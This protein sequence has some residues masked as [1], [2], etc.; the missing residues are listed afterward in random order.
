ML[1]PVRGQPAELTAVLM[2]NHIKMMDAFIT[3]T[4]MACSS[5]VSRRR[6]CVGSKR[7]PKLHQA[8]ACC[9]RLD[10]PHGSSNNPVLSQEFYRAVSN[11][12]TAIVEL[13]QF[14]PQ[15]RLAGNCHPDPEIDP[16]LPICIGMN[17]HQVCCQWTAITTHGEGAALA[18]SYLHTTL[19]PVPQESRRQKTGNPR[20]KTT[21]HWLR[22][23]TVCSCNLSLLLGIF[24][25]FYHMCSFQEK[26][27]K[28][29]RIMQ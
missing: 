12:G 8:T 15:Q 10:I 11:L 13:Q 25:S 9:R 3:W 7:Q 4:L 26:P 20:L 23:F 1:S 2:D 5:S 16:P 6:P 27:C 24:V 18:A 14:P 29:V 19:E 17:K 28:C 22:H 21:A